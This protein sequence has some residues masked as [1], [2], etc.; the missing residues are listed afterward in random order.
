MSI[1]PVPPL[2]LFSLL[3]CSS[4]S[5][6]HS[7]FAVRNF[8]F[9]CELWDSHDATHGRRFRIRDFLFACA[10]IVDTQSNTDALSEVYK[11]TSR[12]RASRLHSR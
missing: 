3:G 7:A 10:S 11:L 9:F 8:S 4:M 12:M 2:A 6:D 5:P 1:V